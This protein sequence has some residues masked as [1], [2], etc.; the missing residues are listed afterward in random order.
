MLRTGDQYRDSLRD[1]R[2]VWIDG[3]KVKDIPNHPIFK[4]IVDIR[5]RIYDMA[6]EAQFSQLLTYTDA[7]SGEK[8]C[9]GSKLPKTKSDW[10]SKRRAIK[11]IMYEVGAVVTRVGDETAGEMWS[12]FDGTDILNEVDP[13]FGD[14]I[15]RHIKTVSESD[16]FH[17]SGN[18]DPKGDRSKLPQDQDPDMLLHAVE[19]TEKGIV[20]DVDF[21]EVS[22]HAKALTPVPGG[23]GPMTIAC[24]LKNTVECFKKSI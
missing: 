11:T 9:I 15:A 13:R 6:H 12:L 2:E 3:K 5:A 23:V 7:T 14:N 4:P 1:G 24:L 20:G 10:S 16:T 8:N 21:R 19:E 18:T 17:V 22:K